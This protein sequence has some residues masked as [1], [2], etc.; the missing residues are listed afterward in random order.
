[1][2]N[3]RVEHPGE[4]EVNGSREG[5][6]NPTGSEAPTSVQGESDHNEDPGGIVIEHFMWGFQ[7]HFRINQEVH[8]KAIFQ[9]L[10]E[11]FVPEVLL[12]G[13][14][15]EGRKGRHAACVEP[16]DDFWLPSKAFN[17][18]IEAAKSLP[19]TY[20]ESKV[21]HSHPR[22]REIET[23]RLRRR[24]IH[25]TMGNLIAGY[26]AK[27]DH[28]VHFASFPVERDG[29]LVCTVLGLQED[30]INSHA[31]LE[32]DRLHIHEYRSF[33]STVSLIDAAVDEFLRDAA[34]ALGRPDAGEGTD[35]LRTP[36]EL[37]RNAGARFLADCA[38]KAD[39]HLDQIGCWQRLF[40]ACNALAALTY[41]GASGR[42]G[43]VLARHDH[44]ALKPT[45]SF[46]TH[47]SLHNSRG[48]RKVLETASRGLRLHINARFIFGLVEV[49][50]F[51]PEQEDL[52]EINVLGQ[53]R[54]E[55][56]H[57]G[58]RMMRVHS[59]RPG[60]PV[61]PFNA[62]KLRKDLSRLFHQI[63]SANVD[64]LVSL[65]DTASAE[66]HGTM[67][68]IVEDAAAEAKRLGNQATVVV[69]FPATP[70]LIKHVTPI[71]GAVLLG[72][73][74]KCYAIGAILDGMATSQGDPARGARF[75][76]ALR[77]VACHKK[78]CLAIV[79]S[80]DG[81]VDLLPDLD[82]MVR[83]SKIEQV[84]AELAKVASRILPAS[85]ALREG[86]RPHPPD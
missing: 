16:E 28:I 2:G 31:Q 77:Y 71:D 70:Q 63:S 40:D 1:M 38:Y 59:G 74:G 47:V 78:P 44:P 35:S 14:L 79:V 12:V 33:K 25:E 17:D 19:D 62:E 20:P 85:G 53:H 65:V 56:V 80:E 23:E 22:A 55:L 54:W 69:P 36:A 83:R 32:L 57:A 72:L 64:L 68:V 43:F 8:A 52:F 6:E 58:R 76:S 21:F 10:D 37:I 27:P 51:A 75:N 34:S 41:E 46:T 42:G 29:Y 24:A 7:H 48:A 3:A 13:V 81:G 11:R 4:K 26:P 18:V 82:P 45:I 5:Q 15:D 67:L 49:G 73:D 86:E 61:P 50:A 66:K 30:V 9:L 84:I 39:R 60:L